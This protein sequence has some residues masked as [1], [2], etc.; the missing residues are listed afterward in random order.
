MTGVGFDRAKAVIP[1]GCFGTF[2]LT[3]ELAFVV[4]RAQGAQ[5]WTSDGREYVDVVLGSGPMVL[6]HGHPRVVE[7]IRRQAERGTSVYAM[8]EQAIEL[9][10]RVVALVPC[11]EAVKFTSSGAEATFYALRLARAATKRDRVLKFEGAYHGHHDYALHDLKPVGEPAYPAAHP[12]SAG[13]PRG[14]TDSMLIAPFNDLETAIRL[15]TEAGEDLAAIVVEPVQRAIEPRPGFLAGL[16]QL[17]DRTGALLVFDEI[18][19]GFRVALGGAQQLYGVQPDLCA[20][21]KI[22]GGGLPLAAVAGR[23]DVLELSDPAHPVVSE[24]VYLS[25]TLNGN[26]LAAAAGLATLDVLEEED[27]PA[28]LER[29]GRTLADRLE[30]T[31]ERL[32]IPLRMIGPG[33]LPEPIFGDG[34]VVDYRSYL[35]TD[36]TAAVAFGNELLRRNVFVHPGT[37]LYSS[38]AHGEAELAR[39]VEAAEDALVAVRDAGL[40]GVG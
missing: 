9:A 26:P 40:V 10:E 34:E 14:V 8:N 7:A 19:T 12:D 28:T 16:R 24:R 33:S 3:D 38:L 30:E 27:G 39:I 37:K 2:R 18:V 29:I 32:S 1:G 21:G 5:L 25:G 6:G 13:I 23:R 20:I 31:A 36:R 11:A 15:A 22:L 17:C 35:K 4:E